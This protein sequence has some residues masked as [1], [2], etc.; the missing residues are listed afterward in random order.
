M[1]ELQIHFSDGDYALFDIASASR[2]S[3]RISLATDLRCLDV[4]WS[5]DYP[6]LREFLVTH[7]LLRK[8]QSPS[9][10]LLLSQICAYPVSRASTVLVL[11]KS[12][13]EG[14]SRPSLLLEAPVQAPSFLSAPEKLRLIESCQHEVS[15]RLGEPPCYC[16]GHSYSRRPN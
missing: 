5:T 14:V 16:D 4:D 11:D 8:L 15:I 13:S 7:T 2:L 9:R 3:P 12:L 6:V 10:T 1:C